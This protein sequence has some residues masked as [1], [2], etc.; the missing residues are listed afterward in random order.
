MLHATKQYNFAMSATGHYVNKEEEE[1]EEGK[2][3]VAKL[4]CASSGVRS[5]SAFH[6]LSCL[7][8]GDR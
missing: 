6:A 3:R 1:E 4:M 7:W 2:I 8:K 5:D